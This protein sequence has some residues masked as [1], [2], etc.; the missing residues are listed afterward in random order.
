MNGSG[1]GG[2]YGGGYGGGQAAGK[3]NPIITLVA[4]E[5][6]LTREIYLSPQSKVLDKLCKLFDLRSF[7]EHFLLHWFIPQSSRCI[8]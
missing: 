3:L 6:S 1:G 4:M 2:G 5:G 7:A 8:F